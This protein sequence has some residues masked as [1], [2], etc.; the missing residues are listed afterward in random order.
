MALI[1]MRIDKGD[2]YLVMMINDLCIILKI[3]NYV[4]TFGFWEQN[5]LWETPRPVDQ[6][7]NLPKSDGKTN[8]GILREEQ[9]QS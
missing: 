7:P 1:M 8:T 5:R 6:S 3:I 4:Q 9:W 2:G